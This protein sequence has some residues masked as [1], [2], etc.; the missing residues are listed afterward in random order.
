[1]Q[2]EKDLLST[3][4]S[5]LTHVGHATVFEGLDFGSDSAVQD[6]W[7]YVEGQ[8]AMQIRQGSLSDEVYIRKCWT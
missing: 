2:R 7:G 3:L 8:V 1:M 4:V 5:C 6:I